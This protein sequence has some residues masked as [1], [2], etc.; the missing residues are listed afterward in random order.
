[1]SVTDRF[2][3]ELDPVAQGQ[4]PKDLHTK[5]ESLI[6]GLQ[7]IQIKA[8]DASLTRSIILTGWAQVW[9]PEAFEEGAEFMEAI[10][11]SFVNAHGQQFKTVFT[12]TLTRILHP[13]GKVRL[14]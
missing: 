11:K 13:I 14:E 4:V 1:M 3:A 5:Y 6:R 12:E 10:A 9:P 2:L 8:C 7:H